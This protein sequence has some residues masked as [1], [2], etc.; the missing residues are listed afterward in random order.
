MGSC[1][2]VVGTP[3]S[4]RSHPVIAES[5]RTT[6]INEKDHMAL[7]PWRSTSGVNSTRTLLFL[8]EKWKYLHQESEEARWQRFHHRYL[9]YEADPDDGKDLS[10]SILKGYKGAVKSLTNLTQ[11][12]MCANCYV[13]EKTLSE[14]LFKCGQCRLIKYCSRD[15]QREHRKK[16]H[17]KQCQTFLD[18][19]Q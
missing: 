17:K 6:M 15:C 8:M 7:N 2:K 4:P 9:V 3:C 13:L 18:S 1:Y 12:E 11:G 5:S 16:A 10:K 14:K 19:S